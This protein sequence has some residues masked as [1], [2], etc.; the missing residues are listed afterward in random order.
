M[1]LF[2]CSFVVVRVCVLMT[3]ARLVL[4]VESVRPTVLLA[5]LFAWRIC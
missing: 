5:A 1:I 4:V 2:G 3:V